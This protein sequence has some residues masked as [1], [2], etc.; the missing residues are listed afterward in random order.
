MEGSKVRLSDQDNDR[1][2]RD[3]ETESDDVSSIIPSF[4]CSC[5]FSHALTN[6]LATS[7]TMSTIQG[8][9]VYV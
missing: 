1:A 5:L 7:C 3:A 2:R 6:L 8:L 4:S 9:Y